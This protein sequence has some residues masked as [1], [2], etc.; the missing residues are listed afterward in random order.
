MIGTIGLAEVARARGEDELASQRYRA[1]MPLT[2]RT[3]ARADPW[4]LLLAGAFLSAHAL[5]GRADDPAAPGV[6][7]AVRDLVLGDQRSRYVQADRPVLGA[8]L[9]G[10]AAWRAATAPDDLACLDMLAVAEAMQSRQDFP[11][12]DRRVHWARA[13]EQFGPDAVGDARVRARALPREAVVPRALD[14]LRAVPDTH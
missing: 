12:L 1:A 4:L 11:A 9:V 10:V 6:A 3:L 5:M 7:G 13:V 2:H 14:L 8:A